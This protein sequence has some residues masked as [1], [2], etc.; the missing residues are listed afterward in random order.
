MPAR[1]AGPP[2]A[3]A[4]TVSAAPDPASDLKDTSTPTPVTEPCVLRLQRGRGAADGAANGL[5]TQ[6]SGLLTSAAAASPK[7]P[8]RAGP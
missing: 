7:D 5:G 2:G 8:G 1:S 6:R 4:M 3:G